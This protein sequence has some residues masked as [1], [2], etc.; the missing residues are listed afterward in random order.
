MGNVEPGMGIRNKE[1]GLG[2]GTRG[3]GDLG[4][5]VLRSLGAGTLFEALAV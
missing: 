5:W 4:T 2:L 3:L 1:W